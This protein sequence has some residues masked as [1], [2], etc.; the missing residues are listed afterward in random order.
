MVKDA[1]Y[2]RLWLHTT[3]KQYFRARELVRQLRAF[4]VQRNRGYVLD[5][6]G[7]RQN[8]HAHKNGKISESKNIFIH[9]EWIILKSIT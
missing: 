9:S 6:K 8:T 4:V 7:I 1:T 5:L 3:Y 2:G